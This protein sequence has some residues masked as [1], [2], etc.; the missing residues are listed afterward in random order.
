MNVT[1]A[2][3]QR[4]KGD[5]EMDSTRERSARRRER[6]VAAVEFALVVPLLVTCLFGVVEGGTRF[7][8]QSQANHYAAVAARDL[9]I[10]PAKSATTVVNGLKVAD[11]NTRAYSIAVS[12]TPVCSPASQVVVTVSTTIDSP[13]GLFGT[14]TVRGVGVARCEN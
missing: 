11:N 7:T 6:G 1:V 14:Y 3:R 4:G 13:S 8:N 2:P 5:T 10:D 12:P 9:A